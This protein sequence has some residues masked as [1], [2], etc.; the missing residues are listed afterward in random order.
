MPRTFKT[1]QQKSRD[2]PPV[3]RPAQGPVPSQGPHLMTSLA[4]G[5][6]LGTGSAMGHR[7]V[8]SVFN[9]SAPTP[10]TPSPK[11]VVRDCRPLWHDVAECRAAFSEEHCQPVYETYLTCMNLP[12]A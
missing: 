7:L 9:A 10:A 1:P 8:A 6:A 11:P 4:E 2:P 12:T 3:P 5:V